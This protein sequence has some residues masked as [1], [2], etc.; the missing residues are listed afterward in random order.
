MWVVWVMHHTGIVCISTDS[1]VGMKRK[2]PSVYLEDWKYKI[3][4]IKMSEFID[5]K[6]KSD[7]R[8]DS[9]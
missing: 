2:Y 4:K 5:T 7:S 6:L 8:S 9:E 3:E 1:V